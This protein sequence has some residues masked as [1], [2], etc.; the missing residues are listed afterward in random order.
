[1]EVLELQECSVEAHRP[2][3][4][5]IMWIVS[6]KVWSWKEFDLISC[7]GRL[8]WMTKAMVNRLMPGSPRLHRALY[9]RDFGHQN[10]SWCE[11]TETRLRDRRLTL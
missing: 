8:C 11:C 5:L 7:T 2:L 10:P 9:P 3:N 4:T 1:M 6:D